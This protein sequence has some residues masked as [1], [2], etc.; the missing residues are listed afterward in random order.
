[1]IWYFVILIYFKL[2][3]LYS[4]TTYY[5]SNALQTEMMIDVGEAFSGAWFGHIDI[6]F[7][8]TFLPKYLNGKIFKTKRRVPCEDSSFLF[9]HL[10]SRVSQRKQLKKNKKRGYK[11]LK[12][13]RNHTI[14][15]DN[16]NHYHNLNVYD[17]D[18]NN[19]I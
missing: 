17:I 4:K 6:L 10:K 12:N 9:Y 16:K 18:Y 1:M 15:I 11:K 5:F 13:S 8:S 14:S 3:L 7:N 19:I 2:S